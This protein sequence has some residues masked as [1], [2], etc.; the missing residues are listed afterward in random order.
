MLELKARVCQKREHAGH[1]LSQGL[2]KIKE[3]VV[4][5]WG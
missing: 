4:V 5:S 1:W 2:K 3:D